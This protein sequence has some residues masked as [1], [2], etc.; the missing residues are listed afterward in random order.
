MSNATLILEPASPAAC[1]RPLVFKVQ[2]RGNEALSDVDEIRAATS[3]D[4]STFGAGLVVGDILVEHDALAGTVAVG[5]VVYLEECGDYSGLRNVLK[6]IE[7]DGG[8]DYLVIESPD[9]GTFTPTVLSKIVRWPLK[10]AVWCEL[11]IYTDAAA[12]PVKVRLRQAPDQDGVAEFNVAPV[13]ASYF[14]SDI[15][16]YVLPIVGGGAVQD[17]HGVTALFYRVRFV[18]AWR[19]DEPM[20]PFDGD[21]EIEADA[22]DS[23]ATFRVAVNA[24]H[25]Y[26]SALTTWETDD[27]VVFRV[28]GTDHERRFLTN[29]PRA[30]I[31]SYDGPVIT[32]GSSDR[33]R[34]FI[35]TDPA[36][37]HEVDYKI[38]VYDMTSGS[39]VHAANV[40]IAIPSA[41]AA[42]AIG[43][44]PADLSPIITL[45]SKYRVFLSN[46][47]ATTIPDGLLSEILEITVDS[48]CPEVRRQMAALNSLGGVDDYCFTG[49]EIEQQ[50]AERATVRKP[51]S[52]GTGFDYMERMHRAEGGS[53]Y[54]LSSK[55][56][57]RDMRRWI[58]ETFMRSANV[59]L[60]L[61][62]TQAA[63][64]I[65]ESDSAESWSSV[66][67]IRP[68]TFDYRLGSGNLSQRA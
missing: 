54:T 65:I 9:Y 1:Y 34:A 37:D 33:F 46:P 26:C 60:K 40:S 7:Q 29:V 61:S 27:M 50:G 51:Y 35:L 63:T 52:T 19:E 67:R 47:T 36:Q 20:D 12:A 66:E 44:G 32:L 14:S 13:L 17:A 3:G 53:T 30:A 24:V 25:P 41:T 6:V 64:V 10:Y 68:I 42:F 5:D 2:G 21:H 4:V 22:T 49:R 57:G 8:T 38:M 58:A 62:R 45:P 59:V 15:S 16:A 39:A 48:S 23:V 43:I 11:L 28:G 31:S 18:E 56:I 55:P